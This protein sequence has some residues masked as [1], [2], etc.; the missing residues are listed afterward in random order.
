MA[1][2]TAAAIGGGLGLIGGVA[3]G[4]MQGNA[5]Q[6]AADT[7]AAAANHASDLQYQEWQQ[8]QANQQ[9]WLQAGQQALTGL[10]DPSFQHDFSMSDF[11][12]DPGYQFRMQQGLDAIQR[13]AAA[14]GGLQ[15]GGTL[16]ALNDYAQGSASQEYQS[17]YDRF[18]NNQTN[19][20]NRLASIAGLGQTANTTLG[21]LGANYANNV[22]NNIMGAG[23][24]AAAAQ[25]ASGQQWGST[26][27]GIGSGV[28]NNWMQYATL[29]K[30]PGF[31]G[32]GGGEPA[33]GWGSLPESFNTAASMPYTYQ[34]QNF[35]TLGALGG[36]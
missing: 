10:Q 9:P 15:S 18:T 19:R 28:G 22:G 2:I 27:G 12:Q 4:I 11:Q 26:L 13:S 21:S 32:G 5:A 24:A 30:M 7:Q 3:G 31:G 23:N 17:A 14:R 36:L 34:S 16:K 33:G 20:F 8:Q 1:F 29:S 25:L 6:N 35:G